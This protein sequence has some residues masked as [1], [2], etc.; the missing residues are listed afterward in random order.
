MPKSD[1]IKL[2]NNF[3]ELAIGHGCSP[4]NLLHIFRTP[5][6]KN[7]SGGLLVLIWKLSGLEKKA[8]S[9]SIKTLSGFHFINT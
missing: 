2:Q 1:F 6:D 8:L 4:I 3:I 7:N 5:F 9:H